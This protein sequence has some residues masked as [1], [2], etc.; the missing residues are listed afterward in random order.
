MNQTRWLAALLLIL[1]LCLSACAQR[2]ALKTAA[3]PTTTSSAEREVRSI[4]VYDGEDGKT[5]LE[6]LKARARV[7]TH[8]SQL[9]ELVI[10]I[11]GA[12]SGNGYNFNYFVNGV[13]PKTGAGNYVTKNG[14]RIEWKLSGP[15]P[16]PKQ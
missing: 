11:N 2:A 14:E 7:R 1:L 5:A 9:G 12:A 3:T 15:R 16:Q 6:L 10:E 13:M 4:I 8:T